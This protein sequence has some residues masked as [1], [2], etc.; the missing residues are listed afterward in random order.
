MSELAYAEDGD[1][2][3]RAGSLDGRTAILEGNLLRILDFD[4][5]ATLDAV[6]LYH[7]TVRDVRPFKKAAVGVC[8]GRPTIYAAMR[9]LNQGYRPVTM[10]EP[11]ALLM[12]GPTPCV[13]CSANWPPARPAGLVPDLILRPVIISPME[14]CDTPCKSCG[15]PE[16]ECECA[17]CHICWKAAAACEHGR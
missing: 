16:C 1:A 5:L 3:L 11:H 8:V 9:L 14:C 15:A 12:V 4:H 13:C 7:Y 6:R 17:K 10:R 2:G